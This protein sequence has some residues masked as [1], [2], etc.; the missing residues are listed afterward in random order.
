MFGAI[1]NI[2]IG[3]VFVVGGLSGQLALRGTNSG[4]LLAAVGGLLLAFGI[5]RAVK[6]SR[7]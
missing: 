5:Y 2:V 6:L 4:P 7:S 1:I 3:L